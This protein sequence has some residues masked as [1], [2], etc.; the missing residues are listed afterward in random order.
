MQ[1][2]LSLFPG[3]G[4]LDMAFEEEGFSVV[5]GPDVL[6]GGDIRKFHPPAGRFD[7]VIGGPPCQMFSPLAR[8]VRHNGHQPKFGNLVPDFERCVADTRPAWFLMEEV[9]QAPLPIVGGYAA[10]SCLL[11]N[12]QLGEAQQRL[13][14]FTFGV[15]GPNYQVLMI[16]TVALESMAYEPPA[17]GGHA[18]TLSRVDKMRVGKPGSVREYRKESS[19]IGKNF[20]TQWAFKNLKKAQGLPEDFDI[21]PFTVAAKCK[22]VGNGV[23]LAMGRALAKAVKEATKNDD[24]RPSHHSRP[25]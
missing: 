2:V 16:D 20:K 21:P 5:R 10:W 25:T 14:R 4:L 8:M 3:I 9:P 19:C 1:L 23:P 11:N 13:R 6:W 22:A 17:T 7:G 15:C 12:R 18:G 24:F